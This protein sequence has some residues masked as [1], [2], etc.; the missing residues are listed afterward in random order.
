[1]N[2]LN[3][4]DFISALAQ[5]NGAVVLTNLKGEILYVNERF[6]NM[7]GYTSE[8]AL[9]Q[10]PSVL[11]SS[12]TPPS[13]YESMW[14]ALRAGKTWEGRMCNKYKPQ[15]DE[16]TSCPQ[17]TDFW[18]YLTVSPIR[19]DRGEVYMYLATH[20]DIAPIV[21]AGK[22]FETNQDETLQSPLNESLDLLDEIKRLTAQ[23]EQGI[24]KLPAPK[25]SNAQ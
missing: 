20:Q 14:K 21:E 15:N 17:D 7:T 13:T 4:S 24:R 23:V 10:T 8:E 5:F 2:Y 11:K 18:V 6:T 25:A 1:M 19:N 16:S 12:K 9:G 22:T 3:E